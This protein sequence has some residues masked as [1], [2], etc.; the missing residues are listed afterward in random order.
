M[1]IKANTKVLTHTCRLNY[2]KRVLVL[3]RSESL[4]KPSAGQWRSKTTESHFRLLHFLTPEL[5]ENGKRGLDRLILSVKSMFQSLF[6][7][8]ESTNICI[9]LQAFN[10]NKMLSLSSVIN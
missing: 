7:Q 10:K 1:K 6:L 4:T 3:Q 5:A 2:E 9:M 8:S